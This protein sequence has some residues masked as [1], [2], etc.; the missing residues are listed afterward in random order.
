MLSESFYV[1]GHGSVVSDLIQITNGKVLAKNGAEGVFTASLPQQ[2]WGI[3]LKIA[4][5]GNRAAP[6]ALLAILDH[7]GALSDAEKHRLQA[8]IS[9]RLLNSRGLDIGQIRPASSWLP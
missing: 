3:A 6:I 1:A 5:G 8:H 7:L 2:G 9:P 4:D